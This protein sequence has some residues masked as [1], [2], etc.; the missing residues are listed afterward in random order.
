MNK[1]VQ[2]SSL[3]SSSKP[4]VMPSMG[5][6]A[7]LLLLFSC[8]ASLF[9]TLKT[10]DHIK[11]QGV[12]KSG[13]NTCYQRAFQ[14]HTASLLNSARSQALQSSFLRATEDC[15][16]EAIDM[17][18]GL[19][20]SIGS[21]HTSESLKSLNNLSAR[22][23]WFHQS[24]LES[25]TVVTDSEIRITSNNIS[26][27]EI[28]R[29]RPMAIAPLNSL[30]LVLENQV[31]N[32]LLLFWTFFTLLSL[33]LFYDYFFFRRWNSRMR[34]YENE[35]FDLES[36][37]FSKTSV[38]LKEF[39]DQVFTLV[40]KVLFREGLVKTARL[41]AER[42]QAQENEISAR[43]IHEVDKKVDTRLNE[44]RPTPGPQVVPEKA[45]IPSQLDH[46]LSVVIERLKN[47]IFANKISLD[48]DVDS[49][50]AVR[51]ASD[52]L[53][54]IIVNSINLSIKTLAQLEQKRC[55]K[56]S[57]HKVENRVRLGFDLSSESEIL[58]DTIERKIIEELS[59]SSEK[60]A[61]SDISSSRI[62]F[63]FYSQESSVLVNVRKG[64]KRELVKTLNPPQL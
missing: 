3:P 25:E 9:L 61:S 10:H 42:N 45:G 51:I 17:L 55:L 22:T 6:V 16:A 32:Y 20:E 49:E 35:A 21:I 27:R 15:Y 37:D 53:D 46:R 57:A 62:G 43:I 12:L 4:S 8:G 19:H 11:Q 34:N 64:K 5:S 7:K 60:I 63:E 33:I 39:N 14:S 47:T 40:H 54:L 38:G 28:E 26:F 30:E 1:D 50:L 18:E 48:L 59:S 52:A 23:H 56:I 58:K 36:I 29:L 13:I 44:K 24:L 31:Q 2:V 41:F